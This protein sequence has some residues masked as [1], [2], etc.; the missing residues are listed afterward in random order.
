MCGR[1]T[2]IVPR[3]SQSDGRRVH[4]NQRPV[5]MT[6]LTSDSRK[7][8]GCHC[9]RIGALLLVALAFLA[10][11]PS[12]SARQ[13]DAAPAPVESLN[14][15][16]GS[17]VSEIRVEGLS[18]NSERL[19]RNN[20][21][22]AVGW[23]LEWA[24][25]RSDLRNI[26]RLGRF[27]NIQADVAVKPDESVTVIFRLTDAPIV[28]DVVIVGNR[29]LTDDQIR[30]VVARSIKL[31]PGVPID[32]FQI[33]QA[34]RAVEELYRAKGFFQVQAA[35]DRSE[36]ESEGI[37]ILRVREGTRIRVTSIRFDGN[38]SF[39][40]K[41]LRPQ[42]RTRTA[43]L[44]NPGPLDNE[45][46]DRDVAAIISF[47]R[48]RGHLDVRASRQVT[49][50]PDGKEAI[51]MFIIDEGPVYTL[52]DITV[53]PADRAA[54]DGLR[55]L[56]AEQ[57]AG[58]IPIK[59]GDVYSLDKL[60]G[61]ARAVE[62]AYLRLGYV[63][64]RVDRQELRDPDEPF[65]DLRLTIFEGERFRTGLIIVRGNELTQQKVVRRRV[66]VKPDRWLDG[67]AARETERRLLESR[68]FKAP[69]QDSAGPRVTI[70]PPNPQYPGYRDVLVQVEETN[71]GSLSFGAAVNSD[72]GVSGLINLNQRNFDL[73]DFPDSL[74]ELLR[75]RAFRG[76]GQTFDL[77]FQP[78]TERS[79]YSLSITEPAFLESHYAV[80]GTGY[81]RQRVFSD[82]D[83]DRLGGAARIARRFGTRWVGGLS[84]RAEDIDISDIDRSATVDVFEV[85]GRNVVTSL[86]FDL[87]RTSVDSRFRPTKGARTTLGVEQVGAFGGDFDFTRLTAEHQ[88]FLTVD[89]DFLGRKTILSIETRVGYIPQEDEAPIFER[90]F[91]GG[92]NFRGFDF[93]G[94]GPRGIKQSNGRVSDDHVGGDFSFFAGAQIERPIWQE[95]IAVVGFVD[96]GTLND[97]ISL[98]NY[99]VSVGLGLRLYLAAFNQAPLA[100]DFAFP[101]AKQSGDDT[102]VFSFAIDIPF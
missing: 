66:E 42:I 31:V 2:G 70:Q 96:S 30:E 11:A 10:V 83:E 94:I 65:V 12:A 18:E 91:L 80:T 6:N 81:F 62:D 4:V 75:G 16:E 89:E 84:V 3:P 9:A 98:E 33:G 47:Y 23:P 24:T 60:R 53:R 59:R 56:T 39:E 61:A 71:T 38:Q 67:T 21:R 32:E 63:D 44:F 17:L 8:A 99:R 102:Q 82:Y 86:G 46:L 49:P 57:I 54:A 14:P 35:I 95:L 13:A 87:T 68:L 50:S 55:V 52:R 100:F 41:R 77:L 29:Q 22:T 34:Q 37:V 90:F 92:R 25:V 76:A 78:G 5:F 51:V 58:L 74:E 15:Y 43:W 27:S 45:V 1:D 97:D 28:Q 7:G 36:L 93:R 20:V 88:V 101:I 85:E 64:V 48:D 69:G 40:D 19:V 79:V 72:A 73:A 26:E